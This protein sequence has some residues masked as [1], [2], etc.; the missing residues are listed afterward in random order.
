VLELATPISNLRHLRLSDLGPYDAV[1]LGNPHCRLYE[2]NL[3]ER[4]R[5]LAEAIT[6]VRDQGKAA[7]VT[8]Y[9]APRADALDALR[10]AVEV[11]ATAGAAAVRCTRSESS[12]S[13]ATTARAPRASGSV[14]Q[15]VH[16]RGR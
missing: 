12:G 11:A 4:P 13:R 15:R 6:I 8:T 9:A 16:Q 10:A 2:G 7:Y 14:R 5:D 1:Y 3:L